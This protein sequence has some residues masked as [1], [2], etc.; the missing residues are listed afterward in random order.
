MSVRDIQSPTGL[1]L[2]PTPPRPVRLSKR[3]GILFVLIVGAV[4]ALLG[5]GIYTRRQMQRVDCSILRTAATSWRLSMQA[6]RYRRT[7]RRN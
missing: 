2:Y 5:Y 3:A 4:L 6:V 1:D 7:F